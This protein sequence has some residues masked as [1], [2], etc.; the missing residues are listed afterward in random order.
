MK[1]Y[2]LFLTIMFIFAILNMS[3]LV[4]AADLFS[5]CV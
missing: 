2:N 1:I 4:A 3:K 5:C